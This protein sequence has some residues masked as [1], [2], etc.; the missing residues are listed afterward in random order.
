MARNPISPANAAF[1]S[2]FVDS[3]TIYPLFENLLRIKRFSD[4]FLPPPANVI[5]L[6]V[7]FPSRKAA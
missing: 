6:P 2:R 5:A 7:T 1:L 3:V 4:E